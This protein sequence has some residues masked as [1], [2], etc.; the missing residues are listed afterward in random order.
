MYRISPTF[1]DL[2]SFTKHRPLVES[3]TTLVPSKGI[4][5][6]LTDGG[7]SGVANDAISTLESNKR[8]SETQPNLY[9]YRTNME[10]SQSPSVPIRPTDP[11]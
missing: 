9:N 1:L 10:Q 2:P 11:Y 3:R 8:H 5:H 7:P 6:P 4:S